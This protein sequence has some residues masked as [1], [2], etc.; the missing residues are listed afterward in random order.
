MYF[1]KVNNNDVEVFW[2]CRYQRVN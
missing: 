2:I 1:G